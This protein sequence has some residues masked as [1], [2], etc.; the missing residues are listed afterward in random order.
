MSRTPS[1]FMNATPG[2]ALAFS[3]LACGLTWILAIP[4]AVAWMNRTAPSPF[5]IGCAGLSAF[6]PLFAALV[7]AGIGRELG[8]VFGRWR[9]NPAWIALALLAPAAVHLAATLLFVAVG[10]RPDSW[11][12]PPTTSEQV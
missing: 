11:F 12:H 2:R 4:T 8:S 3:A 1:N 10:G 9:T 6:G 7:V 5:A